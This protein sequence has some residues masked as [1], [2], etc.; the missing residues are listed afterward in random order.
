MGLVALVPRFCALWLMYL[1]GRAAFQNFD[2]ARDAYPGDYGVI[3]K[4]GVAASALALIS[5]V[6][7]AVAIAYSSLLTR[8]AAGAWFLVVFAS[9]VVTWPAH[10][11]QV[12]ATGILQVLSV[13]G[14]VALCAMAIDHTRARA[15]KKQVL[16]AVPPLAQAA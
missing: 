7:G 15:A 4:V 8:M 12:P 6:C 5:V 14:L 11:Y 1:S 9:T 3:L 2:V 10:S 16:V 13:V